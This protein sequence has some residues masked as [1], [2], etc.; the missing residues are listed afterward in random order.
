MIA[1]VAVFS[2]LSARGMTV[3][4]NQMYQDPGVTTA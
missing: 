3:D 1:G 4:E 2:L